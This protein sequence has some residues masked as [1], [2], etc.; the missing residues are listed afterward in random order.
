MIKKSILIFSFILTGLSLSAQETEISNSMGIGFHL[1][2][3]QNDFGVGVNVV[4][5]Y[6]LKNTLAIRLRGNLMWL[7]HMDEMTE[8]T[9]TPYSN[10]SLGIVSVAG[11]IGGFMRL[12]SEGGIMLL[13]PSSDFS[14]ESTEFG[15]FGLF[16]F[17]FF[18]NSKSN[19]FIELGGVGTGANADKVPGQP[20]YSNGLMMQVGFR[21]QF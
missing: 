11:E 21:Q 20:I 8:T 13:F 10:L 3:Y 6:F 14:S 17:E 18:F 15:G 4:S 2:Q 7:E 5:P 16:G 1:A 12:Y 19:Y 9:W